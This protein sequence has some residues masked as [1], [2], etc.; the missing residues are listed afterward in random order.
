M[1]VA[2]GTMRAVGVVSMLHEPAS[3]NSATR[4]FRGDA[5]LTWTLGRLARCGRLAG[6]RVVCWDD[7]SQGAL[8]A[9]DAGGHDDCVVMPLGPRTPLPEVDAISAARRWSDG[10]RGGPLGSTE[11]DRGFHGPTVAAVLEDA[12]ADA[13]VLVDPAAAL[14]DPAIIDGLI[15]LA[16]GRPDLGYAFAPAA[17]GLGGLL[18][19]ATTVRALASKS[20]H[21]GRLMTYHPANPVADP[22]AGDSCL[23]IPAPVARTTRRYALDSARSRRPRDGRR[24]AAERDAAGRRRC[25]GGCLGDL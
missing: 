6:V 8:A 9:A 2:T 19:R 17:P 4:R 20:M 16:T 23:P 11:F 12:G 5:V 7:Q 1:S 15:A 22:I 18:L 13:A 3:A 21:P 25:D 10:W 14:V 24:R